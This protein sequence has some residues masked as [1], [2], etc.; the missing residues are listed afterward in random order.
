MS[1]PSSISNSYRVATLSI[2]LETVAN[3][4]SK[5][6]K[7]NYIFGQVRSALTMQPDLLV[8]PEACW[9]YG[10]LDLREQTE[11]R[12]SPRV[13]AMAALARKHRCYIAMPIIEKR[14]RDIFNTLLLLDRRG[15]IVWH[16]DKVFLTAMELEFKIKN[17]GQLKAYDADFGRVGAAICFDL[18]FPELAYA[19]KEQEVDVIL[20]SSMYRGG[21]M[22][23]RWALMTNAYIVTSTGDEGSTIVDPL[24]R[25]MG[26]TSHY[27]PFLI[28]DLPRD[29]DVFHI[30]YNEAAWPGLRAKYGSRIHLEIES[31]LAHFILESRDPAL[32]VSDLV[33]EHKLLNLQEALPKWRAANAATRNLFQKSAGRA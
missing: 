11:S 9:E 7:E 21:A 32:R 1:K 26:A 24:G 16:F 29:Y 13:R 30:A 20:F 31:Q 28:R 25:A 33:R 23:S 15:Q 19:W 6:E 12:E 4:P 27:N 17:G 22:V 10:V 2:S 18:N 3:L 14:G 8:L 5:A